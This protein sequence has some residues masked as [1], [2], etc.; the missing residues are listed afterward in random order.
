MIARQLHAQ[1]IKGEDAA[2]TVLHLHAA[3]IKSFV[4]CWEKRYPKWGDRLVY[5]AS[6]VTL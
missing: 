2:N 3:V 4:T 1:Y 6:I 5:S